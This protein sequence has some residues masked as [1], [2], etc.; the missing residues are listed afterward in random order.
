M[1]GEEG[2]GGRRLGGEGGW[3]LMRS[4]TNGASMRVGDGKIDR[5]I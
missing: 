5:T 4:R 3:S 2:K 1:R